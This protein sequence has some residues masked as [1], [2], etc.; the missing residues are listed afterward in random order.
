MKSID[1]SLTSIERTVAAIDAESLTSSGGRHASVAM[2]VRP[3]GDQTEML[4][5]QR[6]EAEQDPWSGQIAFPGGGREHTDVD[7]IHTS[8]RETA[9]EIRL[10]LQREHLIGHLMDQQGSNRSGSIDLVIRCYVFRA[11]GE[12]ELIPNYE[13]AEAFW[14]PLET[15]ADR[16]NHFDYTTH[17]KAGALPAV[18]LG[19]GQSGQQRV[20]WGLTYRFVQQFM[21][22]LGVELPAYLR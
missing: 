11:L 10:N 16:D 6:A 19:T 14:V 7:L 22:T 3:S 8:I 9:E 17:L 4:F 12:S 21:A 15:I 13:V 18:D 5:I 1:F 2:V 20:L